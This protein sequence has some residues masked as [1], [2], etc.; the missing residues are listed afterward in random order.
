MGVGI[1]EDLMIEER[2]VRWRIVEAARRERAKGRRVVASNR[3]LW[4]K[5]IKW[6]WEEKGQE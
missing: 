2:R 5:G 6:R 4:V 1:D 3:E